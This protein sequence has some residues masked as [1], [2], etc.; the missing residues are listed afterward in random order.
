MS[1]GRPERFSRGGCWSRPRS[2][3][4]IARRILENPEDRFESRGIRLVEV[5]DDPIPDPAASGSGRVIRGG[6]WSIVPQIARVALRFDDTPGYR[7][8]ALGFRLVEVVLEEE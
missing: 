1:D 5:V 2:G 3:V 6:S 8:Y 4:R 7:D